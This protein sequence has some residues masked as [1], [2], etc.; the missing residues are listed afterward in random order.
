MTT[1]VTNSYDASCRPGSYAGEEGS[2]IAGAQGQ[3]AAAERDPRLLTAPETEN[4]IAFTRIF[5]QHHRGLLLAALRIA[6][7]GSV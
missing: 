1:K 4:R 7:M 2:A 3:T 6:N 5:E